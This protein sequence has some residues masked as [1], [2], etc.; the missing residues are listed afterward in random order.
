MHPPQ[1]ISGAVP[2]QAALSLCPSPALSRV[3][4]AVDRLDPRSGQG[5]AEGARGVSA[6]QAALL[7]HAADG[8]VGTV[9]CAYRAGADGYGNFADA[10]APAGRDPLFDRG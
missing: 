10:S 2:V 6:S 7:D 4:L 9:G 8:A 1:D 3:L 5:D